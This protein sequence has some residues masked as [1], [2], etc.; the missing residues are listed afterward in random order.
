LATGKL[1]GRAGREW[2]TPDAASTSLSGLILKR[3]LP[4]LRDDARRKLHLL[5]AT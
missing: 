3:W 2:C 5:A 1:Y 4:T